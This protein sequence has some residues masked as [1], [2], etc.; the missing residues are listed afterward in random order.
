[1]ISR[2]SSASLVLDKPEVLAQKL[3][4][5][6]PYLPEMTNSLFTNGTVTFQLNHCTVVLLEALLST[7]VV[8][9]YGL[10]TRVL[11]LVRYESSQ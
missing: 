7:T 2:V 5:S 3:R 9:R 8:T 6:F 1:M 4:N 10:H 11:S